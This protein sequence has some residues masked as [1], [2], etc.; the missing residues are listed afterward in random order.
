MNHLCQLCAVFQ[1]QFENPAVE[2]ESEE[3]GEDGPMNDSNDVSVTPAGKAGN[4]FYTSCKKI[5]TC[6]FLPHKTVHT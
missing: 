6:F 4:L 3:Q 1:E 2:A 5:K